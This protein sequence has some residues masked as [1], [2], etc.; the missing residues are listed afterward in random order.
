M[1]IQPNSMVQLFSDLGLD[2]NYDN[3]LYFATTAEKDS[4][5][6]NISKIATISD[7]SYSRSN[8]GFIRVANKI[9]N[10]YNAGYMRF[11]NTNFE[12]KW[13]YAFITGI[14]YINNDCTQ[15]NFEIDTMMSWMGVF[16]LG[17][18]FVERQHT[19]SDGIG[20]NIADE[21]LNIGD[22]VIEGFHDYTYDLTSNVIVFVESSESGGTGGGVTGGIYNGCQLKYFPSA[23]KA[24]EHI[25]ELIDANKIDNVIKIYMVPAIYYAPNVTGNP[26]EHYNQRIDN[27]K[28]YASLDGYVPKNNKLFVYPYKYAEVTNSEGDRKDFKYEYFNTVPGT[29][30]SGN[31]SFSHQAIC[32][33]TTEALFM[34]INYKI[35]SMVS[36]QLQVDERVSISNFPLCSYNIDTYRAYT[37]QVNSNLPVS[38]FNSFSNGVITGAMSGGAI[39]AVVGGL[40][41]VLPS[42][43]NA[44]AVNSFSPEMGTRNQGSQESDFLLASGN[45]GFRIFEKCITYNYASMIDDYFTAFGYAVRNVRTPNMNARPHWTYVKTADCTV[46]GKLPSDDASKIEN[47][48]NKGVRFWKNHNEIGDFS[49]D[50]SPS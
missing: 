27:T 29:I 15:I 36:N 32:A 37:A 47:I 30:S 50:N 19:E 23:E 42:I 11:K 41:S 3:C 5:F 7:I 43:T 46:H 9:A 25:N 20:E 6:D 4:Y 45:K 48:F 14:E 39:G 17:Q 28:P 34:P 1:Y 24:N 13:F 38:A 26:L 49:L 2:R 35:Q 31:Y 44:L 16:T 8:K 40:T 12:N 10:I 33:A 18:C 21:G 22:Y